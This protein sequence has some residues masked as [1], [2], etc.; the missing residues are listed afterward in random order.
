M[1]EGIKIHAADPLQFLLLAKIFKVVF[2]ISYSYL[3]D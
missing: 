3:F 2:M 1:I